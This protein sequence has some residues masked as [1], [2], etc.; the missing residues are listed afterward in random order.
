MADPCVPIIIGWLVDNP[1]EFNVYLPCQLQGKLTSSPSSPYAGR[2]G[3][4]RQSEA[5]IPGPSV[6]GA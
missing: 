5:D 3:S 2:L 6:R 1:L 4:V